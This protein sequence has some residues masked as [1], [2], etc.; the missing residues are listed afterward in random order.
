MKNTY[1]LLNTFLFSI[2]VMFIGACGSSTDNK[3][4]EI[5]SDVDVKYHEAVADG[6]ERYVAKLA[7]EGMSCEMMCG[8]KIASTLQKING[9]KK[10]DI[11]FIDAD[12]QNYAIVEFD[13]SVVNEKEI[14]AGVHAIADGIYQ[15]KSMDITHYKTAAAINSSQEK[16]T[17]SYKPQLRYKMP[18]IF[19]ALVSL[20]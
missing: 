3:T 8:N 10:V 9:I 20:L 11:E 2:L 1:S 7:I 15:V 13:S 5:K 18:N 6:A 4:T 12:E 16:S 14:I 19:S 17:L